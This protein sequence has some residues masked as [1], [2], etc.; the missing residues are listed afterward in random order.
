MSIDTSG[1]NHELY[2]LM[3][4][5]KEMR[6]WRWRFYPKTI[7]RAVDVAYAAHLR[8]LLEF[9]HDG[10]KNA[11]LGRI[12]CPKPNDLNASAVAS[13]LGG[14]AWTDDELNRLCDADKLLGHLSRDRG[15]RS[16]DWGRSEDWLLLKGYVDRLFAAVPSGLDEARVAR[17]SLP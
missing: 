8:V 6:S 13:P 14:I 16:A 15:L 17:A 5:H 1:L 3:R 4:L 11:D 9:F 12:G 10:R 7:R 2:Q